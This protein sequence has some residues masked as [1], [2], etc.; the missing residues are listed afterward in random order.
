MVTQDLL[1]KIQIMVWSEILQQ[2]RTPSLLLLSIIKSLPQKFLKSKALKEMQNQIT[3]NLT[4]VNLQ[5]IQTLKKVKNMSMY[6]LVLGKKMISK[7]QILLVNQRLFNVEKFHSQK[8]L[9]MPSI[10]VQ[11]VLWSTIMWKDQT[12]ECQLM[13]MLR[14]FHLSS[15]QNAMGKLLKLDL[16]KLSLTIP[17]PTVHLQKQTNC[18]ISQAGV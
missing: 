9:R 17:W 1:L 15:F 13:G 16:T 10:M 2:Q 5:Q 6:L 8:K 14:K 11:Q 4:T 12:L 18:L 7:I 3:G